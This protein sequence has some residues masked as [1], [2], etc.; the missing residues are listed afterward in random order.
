LHLAFYKESVKHVFVPENHRSRVANCRN[1]PTL[2]VLRQTD[3]HSKKI[4]VPHY[5]REPSWSIS[6][7]LPT[8][9]KL[10]PGLAAGYPGIHAFS[11]AFECNHEQ[12]DRGGCRDTRRIGS[13]TL[14]ERGPARGESDPGPDRTVSSRTISSSRC[15]RRGRSIETA[16]E[17]RVNDDD[18]APRISSCRQAYRK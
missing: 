1:K 5:S 10:R 13:K 11:F 4:R 7:Y 15:V 17:P 16:P 6:I 12:L 18:E 14:A 9:V 2:A 8:Y 3:K